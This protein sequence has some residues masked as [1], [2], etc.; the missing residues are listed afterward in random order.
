MAE[1]LN[2]RLFRFSLNEWWTD[3]EV[4]DAVA[5]VR[6]VAEHYRRR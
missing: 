3:R 4:D 6:K 2:T 1:S 5:A